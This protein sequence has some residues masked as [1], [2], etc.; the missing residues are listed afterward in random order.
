MSHPGTN[1]HKIEIGMVITDGK[2]SGYIL[3]TGSQ[4]IPRPMYEYTGSHWHTEDSSTVEVYTSMELLLERVEELFEQFHKA[5]AGTPPL[6]TDDEEAALK[7]A[8]ATIPGL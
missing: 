8:A 1:V 6:M 4:P 7:E 5:T 2:G 3:L